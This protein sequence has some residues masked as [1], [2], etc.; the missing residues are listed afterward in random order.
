[1]ASPALGSRDLRQS[2]E[3]TGR[4]DTAS[5][6]DRLRQACTEALEAFR[7]ALAKDNSEAETETTPNQ[8]EAGIQSL[9][10]ARS[11]IYR[12]KIGGLAARGEA[13]DDCVFIGLL[14]I[15]LG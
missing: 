8:S 9:M 11:A 15:E 1:M 5:A 7:R 6:A 10:T 4:A 12:R 13:P 3:D 2:R 14:R